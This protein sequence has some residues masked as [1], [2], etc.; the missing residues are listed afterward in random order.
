MKLDKLILLHWGIKQLH[1]W[2]KRFNIFSTP[3]FMFGW[4]GVVFPSGNISI[5]QDF[6]TPNRQILKRLHNR[7]KMWN[8]NFYV[9]YLYQLFTIVKI[10]QRRDFT[11]IINCLMK[12]I[13]GKLTK[14][15]V[16]ISRKIIFPLPLPLPPPSPPATSLGVIKACLV[17]K[18]SVFKFQV[19]FFSMSVVS[20]YFS[21]WPPDTFNHPPW[22]TSPTHQTIPG[23]KC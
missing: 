12:G 22:L 17:A 3:L 13:F 7:H 6:A 11:R 18:C 8:K 9:N 23:C 19:N 21:F 15:S 2:K 16:P 14:F 10:V 20:F 1:P 5:L 4:R